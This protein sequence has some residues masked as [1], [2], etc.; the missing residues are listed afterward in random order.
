MKRGL[1]GGMRDG[2]DMEYRQLGIGNCLFVCLG[3]K[4]EQTEGIG[5]GEGRYIVAVLRGGSFL[6]V[7]RSFLHRAR[8]FVDDGFRLTRIFRYLFRH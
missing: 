7:C 1:S 4:E 8:S 3:K 5:G 2:W 6:P